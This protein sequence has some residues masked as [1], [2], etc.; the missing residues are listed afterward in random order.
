MFCA[1]N[2]IIFTHPPRCGGTS[3]ESFLGFENNDEHSF[4]YKHASLLDHIK[5]IKKMNQN[6][7]DFVK[8]SVIRNP[9]DRMVSWYFHLKQKALLYETL[10]GFKTKIQS[11]ACE[12]E[13]NEFINYI[14]KYQIKIFY[15]DF[16][17]YMFGETGTIE[18]DFII[19]YEN[20]NNDFLKC[21]RFLKKNRA[22]LNFIPVKNKTNENKLNYRFFFNKK[23][24]EI[25]EK[26]YKKDI[27][28][29]SYTFD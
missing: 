1:I 8:I 16:S 25:I 10:Y 29:F 28:Y 17:F 26:I 21:L 24:K 4:L 27:D 22:K 15:R 9:W 2:K 20:Y 19:K 6:P 23:S 14:D 18:I 13:F 7:N 12:L 5:A 3:F 11:A